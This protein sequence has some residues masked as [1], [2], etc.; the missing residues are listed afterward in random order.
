VHDYSIDDIL[1]KSWDRKIG[2]DL[3]AELEAYTGERLARTEEMRRFL[4]CK[5]NRELPE[6]LRIARGE[7]RSRDAL[8]AVAHA[9]RDHALERPALSACAFRAP[10][11]D[12]SEWREA[13]AA[14]YDFM[15]EL[16]AECG[17]HAGDAELALCTLRSLVRGFVVHEVMGSFL[18]T[19]PYDT[20]F[21]RAVEIFLVG[22][23]TL[24]AGDNAAST[25]GTDWMSTEGTMR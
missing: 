9:M 6:R 7:K 10:A 25:V 8:R 16:L 4:A 3:V 12:C 13:H 19:F 2:H 24:A 22:V 1:S 11:N 20:A 14:L 18:A 23:S 5:A 17:L 15:E 21:D